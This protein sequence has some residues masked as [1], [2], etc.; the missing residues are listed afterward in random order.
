VHAIAGAVAVEVDDLIAEVADAEDDF[1]EAGGF[2][3]ADKRAFLQFVT[4]VARPPLLGFA[5]LVPRFGIQAVRIERDG[6]KLPSAA[7]CFS[8]LKLPVAYSSE[9]VLREKLLTAIRSG[10]GFE[11]T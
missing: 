2:E 1:G 9:A 6:D 11:L 4:A 7:T 5:S 3:E 8:L 10:A